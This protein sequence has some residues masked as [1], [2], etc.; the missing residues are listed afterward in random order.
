MSTF[1]LFS[2]DENASNRLQDV[3]DASLKTWMAKIIPDDADGTDI[4][5]DGRVMEILREHTLEGY[6]LTGRHGRFNS[7]EALAM[8]PSSTSSI[9]CTT[10]TQSGWKIEARTEMASS[11][12]VAQSSDLVARLAPGPQSFHSPGS[13]LSGPR[14]Q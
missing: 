4:A 8:R 11:H 6:L 10:S 3:Y 1:R 12:L 14:E 2:P 7:Y 5:P 9:R 13:R